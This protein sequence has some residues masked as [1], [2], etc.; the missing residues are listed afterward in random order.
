M[1][2]TTLKGKV[3]LNP[4]QLALILDWCQVLHAQW[5]A[6]VAAFR[7]ASIIKQQ[8]RWYTNALKALTSDCKG[9]AKKA[10]TTAIESNFNAGGIYPLHEW[11][12]APLK[13]PNK[14]GKIQTS[15]HL[16][17]RLHTAYGVKSVHEPRPKHS[18]QN[19]LIEFYHYSHNLLSPYVCPLPP[20]ADDAKPKYNKIAAKVR[21]EHSLGSQLNTR[22]ENG[23]VRRFQAAVKL[24]FSTL[25]SRGKPPKFKRRQDPLAWLF[26]Y[27]SDQ[28]SWSSDGIK[29]PGSSQLGLLI[30][31]NSNLRKRLAGYQGVDIRSAG[32][33]KE[34]DGWYLSLTIGYE[35]SE[36][37][38]SDR[39]FRAVGIDMGVIHHAITSDGHLFGSRETLPERLGFLARKV[40]RLQLKASGQKLRSKG[41]HKTQQQIRQCKAT[42]ARNRKAWAEALTTRLVDQY[43]LIAVEDLSLTNMKGKAQAKV[44][45]QGKWTQ[46]KAK[47]K[48]GLNRSLA[49]AAPGATLTMLERKAKAAGKQVVR[50]NPAFTSQTCSKCG[51]VAEESRLSQAEFLCVN[52]GHADNADINAAKNILAK[53]MGEIS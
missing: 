15:F 53:A 34:F 51:H 26:S 17:C 42:I 14:D 46:N 18:D 13:Y 44:D 52:C 35:A 43:D 30:D 7:K 37:T 29:L 45:E 4:A 32:L 1:E 36:S 39:P 22:Y 50:I 33:S 20:Q 3:L 23:L 5:N 6:C 12:W 25:S 9:K 49:G 38:P 11:V 8:K 24:Y 40:E 31:Q 21:S 16:S 47:A 48:T 2:Y 10:L 41:W 19:T 28:I 27:Q